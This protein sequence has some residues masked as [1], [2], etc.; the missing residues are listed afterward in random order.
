[1]EKIL[2]R[3]TFVVYLERKWKSWKIYCEDLK[4]RIYFSYY[5]LNYF[6]S[7][8]WI[9]LC[10]MILLSFIVFHYIKIRRMNPKSVF[11]D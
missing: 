3:I 9:F 10:L 2:R 11:F 1:M 6:E 7:L 5:N 4:N 8:N